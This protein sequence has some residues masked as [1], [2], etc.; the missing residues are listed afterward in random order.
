[1]SQSGTLKYLYLAYLSKPS[2]QRLLY[3]KIR[4]HKVASILELGVG[5]AI[6]SQRML[7]VASRYRSIDELRF[8]GVDMFEARPA[9]APGI[10]LKL[11]HKR[12]SP[13]AARVQLAPGD[14]SMVLTRLANGLANT[15]LI[16]IGADHDAESLEMAW[17]YFPRM[18][19]EDTLVFREMVTADG[20]SP[21][22][23]SIDRSEID[24]LANQRRRSGRMAA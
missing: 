22:L 12:L 5:D 21:R 20:G 19:H 11:A 8:T 24:V 23:V 2:T 18:M 15:D 3:R 4:R 17:S 9:D 10:T 16:I 1:M 7:Q 6:R 14:P 13:L